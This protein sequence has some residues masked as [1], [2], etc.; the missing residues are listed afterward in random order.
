MG[1]NL[2]RETQRHAIGKEPQIPSSPSVAGGAT[3]LTMGA[4][5]G[6]SRFFGGEF[7]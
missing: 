5:D 7:V 1:V 3:I 6:G 4:A 2:R